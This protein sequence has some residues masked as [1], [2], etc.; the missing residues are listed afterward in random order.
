MKRLIIIL[1]P[2]FL[3]SLPLLLLADDYIDDVYYSPEVELSNTADQPVRQPYY[4]KKAM[5]QIIFVDDTAM[6]Q[7]PDTVRAII[8]R[9][10]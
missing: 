9:E 6:Q 10:P 2:V 7:H 3:L 1:L 5:E 4:N 8:R